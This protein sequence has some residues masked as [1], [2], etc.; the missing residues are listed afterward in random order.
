MTRLAQV[1]DIHGLSQETACCHNAISQVSSIYKGAGI[2]YS[3][4]V[5]LGSMK[6]CPTKK[7]LETFSLEKLLNLQKFVKLGKLQNPE[8][9]DVEN[10]ASD[11]EYAPSVVHELCLPHAQQIT[12]RMNASYR[13]WRRRLITRWKGATDVESQCWVQ[14]SI[15]LVLQA[16]GI[17]IE[18][19]PQDKSLAWPETRNRD[20]SK[21]RWEAQLGAARVC[22]RSAS[23]YFAFWMSW[24]KGRLTGE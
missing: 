8:S 5:L 6:K 9:K 1:S 13:D 12:R 4:Q 19:S 15:A 23:V 14:L 21:R 17:Y 10:I 11:S 18:M 22:L 16:N 2:G 20:V 24:V 3:S 7:F